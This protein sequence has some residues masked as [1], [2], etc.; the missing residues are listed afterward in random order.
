M[1]R[2]RLR[3]RRGAAE[4]AAARSILEASLEVRS[5]IFYA[6]LINVVAVVPVLF[7]ERP[8]GLVLP[9]ARA[10]LRAGGARLDARRADG[11]AGAEPDPA[12]ARARSA[13]ASAPLVRGLKRGYGAA[14]GARRSAGRGPRYLTV[15][16]AAAGGGLAVAPTLG[17]ELFPGVQGARLPHALDHRA[18]HVASRGAAHR[19]RARSQELRASPRRPRLR[20]AH[21]PGVPRRGD[22]GRRT[23]A[24]TGSASTRT[25]TTTRRSHAL[26]DVADAHPGL[27]R[28][29]QTYLRERIDEV[30]AG[31][32]RADRR[33]H[34]R[35]RP[36]R[37][38][39]RPPT[40]SRTR[41]RTSPASTDLHTVAAGRGAADRRR[42]SSS[43][44]P[45][46]T[47]S[48]RATCAAP[49][50][51]LVASEEVGDIFRGG[52]P[53]N[54]MVWSTPKTRDSLTAIR[55]LP[56]DTPDRRAGPARRR[57]RRARSA[58]RRTSS[59]ARTPRAGSTS[60]PTCPRAATSAP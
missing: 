1:R 8:H 39:A 37:A 5:A 33:A 14:A 32:E 7:L 56:I 27:Y 51:T 16:A 23:S 34:L 48:S 9:A 3:A 22:R 25:P 30:L 11:H 2:L 57:R 24:R 46:A 53:T 18:R 47:A 6:T 31:D 58:R 52:V 38:A 19:H 10:L 35:R 55:N 43:A 44:S 49:P 4:L 15:A 28:N 12:V 45:A 40:G 20:L 26:H 29:V 21:R 59:S 13:P 54:V 60:A 42:A 17:E 50:A 41:S 36:G